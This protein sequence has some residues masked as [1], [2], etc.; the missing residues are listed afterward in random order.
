MDGATIRST[1]GRL[2]RV[3]VMRLWEGAKLKGVETHETFH[4][5]NVRVQL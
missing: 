5:N 2:E 3:T 1:T 4:A